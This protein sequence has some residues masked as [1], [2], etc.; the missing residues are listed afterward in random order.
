MEGTPT[1]AQQ[2]RVLLPSYVRPSCYRIELKPCLDTF[3][4]EGIERVL[5]EGKK[6]TMMKLALSSS[7]LA[8][9]LCD[10]PSEGNYK[11][12]R[13]SCQRPGD[14]LVQHSMRRLHT[15]INIDLFG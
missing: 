12:N 11:G 15:N 13:S 8:N 6:L 4:F 3:T 1:V 7:D 14:S 2:E 9:M 10:L 5:I